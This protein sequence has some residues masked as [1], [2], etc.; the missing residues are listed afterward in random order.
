MRLLLAS[1]FVLA[2]AALG[3]AQERRVAVQ[4]EGGERIEG[5]VVAMDLATLQVRV[6]GVVRT[7][8][9]R[10]IA[11][12]KFEA[13]PPP[14]AEEGHAA[15]REDAA[16]APA[17]T[18]AAVPEASPAVDAGVG[19]PANER[20]TWTRPIQD[21]LDPAVAAQ[22]PHDVRH[23]SLLRRRLQQL[24]ESY[25]WLQPTAPMQWLS[26]GLLT[27]IL[28]GLSVH[29]SIKIAGAEGATMGRSLALAAWYL[30]TGV[31]QVAMVPC[32]DFTVVL[33][34][35]ANPTL[36]LLWLTGAFGLGRAAASIAFAVQLGLG[37]LA[38]GVLEL[39]TAVLASIGTPTA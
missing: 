15:V 8:D 29:A 36:A 28:M 22:P 37:V 13:A 7:I 16:A 25:P 31:V 23:Q 4:L 35:L 1:M 2:S 11:E 34:L 5:S 24:D 32:N 9:A 14:A 38:Y 21:P 6:D 10:K 26:L 20:I 27:V 17:A 39:V 12:C 19:K 18:A 33:M 3:H 30:F